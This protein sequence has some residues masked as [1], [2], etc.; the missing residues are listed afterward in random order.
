MQPV[1]SFA[2]TPAQYAALGQHA[3]AELGF[4]IHG[5]VGAGKRDGV[6]A[7]WEYDGHALEITL[8]SKPFIVSWG[9]V[10]AKVTRAVQKALAEVG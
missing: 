8:H 10:C 5:D 2:C 4:P 3:A 9:F 1:L 7:S 6:V